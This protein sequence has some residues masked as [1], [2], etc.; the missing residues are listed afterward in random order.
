M[1]I[2]FYFRILVVALAAHFPAIPMAQ[3]NTGLK[4]P[5][6]DGT[7][8]GFLYQLD[9]SLWFKDSKGEVLKI[10]S[11]EEQVLKT[12]KSKKGL[13]ARILLRDCGATVDFATLVTAEN[14][15]HVEVVAAFSG[16]P[17]VNLKWRGAS[18]LH[19]SYS[20]MLEASVF[21]HVEA[22]DVYTAILNENLRQGKIVDPKVIQFSSMNYGATGRAAGLPAELLLRWAG[23]SQEQSGLHRKEWGV[24]SGSSPYG[25][26]PSGNA[27][28][29]DGIEYEAQLSK[30]R[31]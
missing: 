28:I 12:K 17:K 6:Q 22:G 7:H 1:T 13:V 23:W 20:K 4:I 14:N 5:N 19:I 8:F 16:K 10:G 11:C 30:S 21:R 3:E 26:D 9:K 31:K 18:E 29:L 15:G 24:W 27:A 25:D 2:N